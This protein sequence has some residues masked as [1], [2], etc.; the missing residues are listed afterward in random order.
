MSTDKAFRPVAPED[1]EETGSGK[2]LATSALDVVS[3]EELR[4]ALRDGIEYVDDLGDEA[5]RGWAMIE[6]D[7]DA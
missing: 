6:G 4:Q 2:A 1:G 7:P 5:Q 3:A